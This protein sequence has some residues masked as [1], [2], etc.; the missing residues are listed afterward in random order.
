MFKAFVYT[1]HTLQAPN[2][3]KSTY[4]YSEIKYLKLRL[5]PKFQIISLV[6]GAERKNRKVPQKF[7]CKGIK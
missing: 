6:P 2:W 3:V 4:L 7:A 5:S 1:E